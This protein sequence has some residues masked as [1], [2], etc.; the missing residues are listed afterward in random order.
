VCI[1]WRS[2]C[3]VVGPASAVTKRHFALLTTP[4]VQ[5]PLAPQ[6]VIVSGRIFAYYGHIRVSEGPHR[7]MVYSRCVQTIRGSP[8]YSACLSDR[9]ALLTPAD[10]LGASD[11]FFPRDASLRRLLTVSASAS[12]LLFGT[13]GSL[14][15]LQV[16]SR[17]R[18]LRPDSFASPAPPGR[19]RPSFRH[20]GSLLN[21]VGYD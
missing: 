21:D 1:S 10:S 16:S 5:W 15:R 9:V 18:G 12:V 8:I 14:T 7:L 20:Q 11:C 6:P 17:F 3:S 4:L 19:L 13:A 2:V